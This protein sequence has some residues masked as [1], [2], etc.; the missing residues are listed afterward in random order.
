MARLGQTEAFSNRAPARRIVI[1]S[2][3]LQNSEAFTAYGGGGAMPANMPSA[4]D[5][6]DDTLRRFG[7]SLNGVA[8][9]IRLIPRQRYVDMQRGALKEY[10][11]QV[12]DELGVNATW[13]DL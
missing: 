4:I 13:R 11:N 8:L 6:A 3:M 2:D 7:D 12:F 9:E 5:V 10:W 1:I